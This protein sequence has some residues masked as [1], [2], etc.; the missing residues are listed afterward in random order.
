MLFGKVDQLLM[1]KFNCP[2]TVVESSQ[3]C[4]DVALRLV[5]VDLDGSIDSC[6]ES[7]GLGHCIMNDGNRE[8][9]AT[10]AQH[11]TVVVEFRYQ[12]RLKGSRCNDKLQIALT[13]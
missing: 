11:G 4:E 13:P 5:E 9:A 3:E 2:F 7:L 10:H 12:V 6:F 8:A 1:A